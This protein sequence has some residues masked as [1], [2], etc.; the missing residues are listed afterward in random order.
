[1]SFQHMFL[2][3]RNLAY[4]HVVIFRDVNVK[5]KVSILPVALVRCYC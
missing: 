1:M 5:L 4:S 3:T 2:V